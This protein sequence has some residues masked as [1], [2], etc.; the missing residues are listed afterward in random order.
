MEQ[1]VLNII[2]AAVSIVVTGLASWGVAVFTNWISSKMKDKKAAKMLSDIIR[3]IT[4]AVMEIFQTFVEALKK[5]GKFD[6]AA[7]QMAKEKAMDK[8]MTRLGEDMKK[9]ISDNYGDIKAW[10]SDQIE[11]IIYQL[12]NK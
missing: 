2:L 4:D 10:I 3:I 6:A 7:Q 9:Y 11:T 12:K 5:E 8:I 1:S